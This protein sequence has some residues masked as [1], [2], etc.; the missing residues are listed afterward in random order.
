M[1]PSLSNKLRLPEHLRLA[2]L[3]D[4]PAGRSCSWSEAV[5]SGLCGEVQA[6]ALTLLNLIAV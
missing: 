5:D 6:G 1:N 3:F 2:S 4:A